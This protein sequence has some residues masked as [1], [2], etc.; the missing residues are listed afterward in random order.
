MNPLLLAHG[1]RFPP[2]G[3]AAATRVRAVS[4]SGSAFLPGELRCPF[5]CGI[6]HAPSSVHEPDWKPSVSSVTGSLCPQELGT[7]QTPKRFLERKEPQEGSPQ[8]LG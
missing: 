4:F 6:P 7:W 1:L 5:L 2:P 3:A 8:I